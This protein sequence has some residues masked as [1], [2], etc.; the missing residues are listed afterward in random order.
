[1]LLLRIV[2]SFLNEWPFTRTILSIIC[3]VQCKWVKS[4]RF[5]SMSVWTF[6]SLIFLQSMNTKNRI[7]HTRA[8]D[9]RVD[10][11]RPQG[12]LECHWRHRFGQICSNS[13][14]WRLF[15]IDIKCMS[16]V[17][18]VRRYFFRLKLQKSY[19]IVKLRWT[20]KRWIWGL[21]RSMRG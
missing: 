13:I 5:L 6:A 7:Q 16:V 10:W 19:E 8:Y 18:V 2:V 11:R 4:G 3:L 17:K 12:K 14:T 1:M 15:T 20:K 21:N 9:V